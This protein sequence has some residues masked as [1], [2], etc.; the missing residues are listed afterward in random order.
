M[1]YIEVG[2]RIAHSPQEVAEML[3]V[4]LNFVYKML[5]NGQLRE[6]NDYLCYFNV[7]KTAE[8]GAKK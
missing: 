3:G 1:N 6:R 7:R 8:K 2:Q 5:K 4:C